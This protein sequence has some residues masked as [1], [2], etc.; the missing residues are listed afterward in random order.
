MGKSGRGT[1]QR[2]GSSPP[3][4]MGYALHLLRT[5]H[6][7]QTQGDARKETIEKIFRGGRSGG[8]RPTREFAYDNK[9]HGL[10][11]IGS[12]EGKLFRWLRK[13][14]TNCKVLKKWFEVQAEG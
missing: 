10:L 6:E 9:S 1:P 5:C 4:I 3:K 11:N 12:H 2:R 7:I 13:V 14:R 8:G